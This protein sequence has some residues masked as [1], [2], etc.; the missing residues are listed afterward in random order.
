MGFAVTWDRT[1]AML[2]E[3][4]ERYPLWANEMEDFAVQIVRDEHR[5]D[6]IE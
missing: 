4:K 2:T 6:E 5:D 3:W 1:P